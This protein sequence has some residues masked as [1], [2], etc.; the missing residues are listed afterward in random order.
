[1]WLWDAPQDYHQIGVE[2]NSQEKLAFAGPD[3][4]KWTHNVMPFGPV[5]GPA[6]IIAFILDVNSL[7]KELACSYGI[8]IDEDTNTNI[9]VNDIL[10]WAKLLPSTWYTWNASSRFV[11]HKIC[12]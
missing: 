9:I 6:T 11:N 1:M 12:C 7:C 10:S 2:H 4:T 3:T 5:K 8:V